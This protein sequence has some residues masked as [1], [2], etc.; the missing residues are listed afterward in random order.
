MT[1]E[2]LTSTRPNVCWPNYFRTRGLTYAA[3][4]VT[5]ANRT[6]R[7]KKHKQFNVIMLFDDMFSVMVSVIMPSEVEPTEQ[8]TLNIVNNC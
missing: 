3:T 8:H 2:Q 1:V 5:T 6:A 4:T 7:F